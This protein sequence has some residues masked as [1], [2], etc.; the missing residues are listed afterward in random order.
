MTLYS[1]LTSFMKKQILIAFVLVLVTTDIVSAQPS[2]SMILISARAFLQ[3]PFTG[4][5][6]TTTLNTL[7]LIP[8]G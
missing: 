7:G 8:H 4:S 2:S 6:M 3:G 5:G 1:P